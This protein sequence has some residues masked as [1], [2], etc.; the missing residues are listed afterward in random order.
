MW[1]YVLICGTMVY[2]SVLYVVLCDTEYIDATYSLVMYIYNIYDIITIY[3]GNSCE[4][5]IY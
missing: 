2:Y 5:Y 4:T 3:L 1:Y